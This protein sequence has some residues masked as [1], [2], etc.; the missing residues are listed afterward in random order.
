[1]KQGRATFLRAEP[2]LSTS[3]I[4]RLVLASPVLEMGVPRQRSPKDKMG[5]WRTSEI[6]EVGGGDA[7]VRGRG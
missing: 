7:G 2:V 5:R 4:H 3:L 1:M 6:D